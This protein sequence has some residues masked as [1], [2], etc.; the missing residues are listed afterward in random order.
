LLAIQSEARFGQPLTADK[1]TG[2]AAYHL[3]RSLPGNIGI[4]RFFETLQSG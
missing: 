1:E 3:L 4:R 2:E